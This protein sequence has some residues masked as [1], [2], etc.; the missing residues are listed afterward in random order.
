METSLKHANK[1]SGRLK[2]HLNLVIG[3]IL[4]NQSRIK[5]HYEQNVHNVQNTKWNSILSCRISFRIV[6]CSWARSSSSWT[7]ENLD[8]QNQFNLN[9][10]IISLF[11]KL[12]ILIIQIDRARVLP[13][14]HQC[15]LDT[16]ISPLSTSTTCTMILAKLLPWLGSSI[17]RVVLLMVPLISPLRASHRTQ[18]K[19]HPWLYTWP[20]SWFTWPHCWSSM[21]PLTISNSL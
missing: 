2:A 19:P 14:Y 13:Y 12:S 7:P 21:V 17:G 3:Q 20:H 15:T 6:C 18:L 9:D 8:N 10:T 11:A 16:E 5:V 4:T 1:K